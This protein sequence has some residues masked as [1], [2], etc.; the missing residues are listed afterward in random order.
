MLSL[1]QPLISVLKR[2][3]IGMEALVRSPIHHGSN[4]YITPL[5]LF[6][7]ANNEN[8]I[9]EFDRLCRHSALNT[10]RTHHRENNELPPNRP[11]LF[12]NIDTAIIDQGVVG[13]G[14][15]VKAVQKLGLEPQNIV[16]ELLE[17]RVKDSYALKQFV[18]TYR[19]YGFLIALDD[20]GSGHSN[21]DRIAILKP[22]IIKID[23]SLVNNIH[24]EFYKQAVFRS[25]AG[26]ARK[27]GAL[28]VAEGIE[29]LPEALTSIELGADFLQG[30]Y[31]A[32]PQKITEQD[33]SSTYDIIDHI[34][35]EFGKKAVKQLRSRKVEYE[36][37]DFLI[38]QMIE[39][40]SSVPAKDYDHSLQLMSQMFFNLECIYV[41]NMVGMQVSKTI[42]SQHQHNNNKGYVYQPA[43]Q[44]TDHSLKN[45]YLCIST[46][47]N[48]HITDSYI[49][50]A[51]GNLCVTVST[52]F[53]GVDNQA[54][55]LCIDLYPQ[56][57]T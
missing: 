53:I 35:D 49:S 23:R 42:F 17:A 27:L 50:L 31:I 39:E 8:C 38:K 10:W 32:H 1:Y 19:E 51:S 3:V 52:S 29:S 40:L 22:D 26:L 7:A 56:S 36:S 47:Q 46:G 44:G 5:A 15:L 55:I 37:Y 20:V 34:A 45:Y 16:I 41:L 13:S 11:L 14:F 33:M 28:V 30:Y 18:D 43:E 24:N 54:Y 25:I 2:S 21:L 48:K 6:A 4:N 9:V 57:Y 12:L